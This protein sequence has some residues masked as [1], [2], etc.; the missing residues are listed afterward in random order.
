MPSSMDVAGNVSDCVSNDGSP[1]PTPTAPGPC[2]A[3]ASSLPP[4][5]PAIQQPALPATGSNISV[6][7]IVTKS[8]PCGGW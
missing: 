3:P 7:P 2:V 6:L 4:S 8:I 1:C 5:S